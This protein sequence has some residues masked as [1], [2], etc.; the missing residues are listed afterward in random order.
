MLQ[1]GTQSGRMF[2]CMVISLGLF[3]VASSPREPPLYI[4]RDAF[5]GVLVGICSQTGFKVIT[6]S[7]QLS[8]LAVFLH[9]NFVVDRST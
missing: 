3:S 8:L 7:F 1:P 6:I 9:S 2:I 5:I 4:T